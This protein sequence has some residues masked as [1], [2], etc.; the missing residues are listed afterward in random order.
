MSK[1]PAPARG[2][3]DF[4]R[5]AADPK[6]SAYETIDLPKG[7]GRERVDAVAADILRKLPMLKAPGAQALDIGAGCTDLPTVLA[8]LCGENGGR[9]VLVDSAEMLD[10][11]PDHPAA[12][13]VAGVF[14]DCLANVTGIAPRYDAILVY[15]VMQYVFLEGNIWRFVDAAASLLK[16]GGRLLLGDLPNASKRKRF[17]ASAAGRAYH[18]AH[19]DPNTDP[20]VVFNRLDLQEIDDAVIFGLMQRLR[21]GGFDVYVMPQPPELPMANRRED[22]LVCR[23]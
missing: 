8:D 5:L 13:K 11:L 9:I 20:D 19:Y 6:L 7:V 18:K 17:L 1:N 2:F 4:R 3:D 10:Q 12:S 14:P 22:L 21:C 15:S 16:P 23:P